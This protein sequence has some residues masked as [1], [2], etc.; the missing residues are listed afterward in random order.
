MYN[1]DYEIE[2][3]KESIQ[4]S[5]QDDTLYVLQQFLNQFH[6]QNKPILDLGSGDG[7]YH[8]YFNN[9]QFIGLDQNKLKNNKPNDLLIE[10]NIE[11]FPYKNIPNEY[12]PFDFIFSLDTFEHLIRPDKV[13]DYLYH[14][15]NILNKNG[16]I[17]I[18][19]PN[20]NTL[21]DKLNNI[22][23]CIYNPELKNYT[24][25]RWNA[26]HLRFFDINSL[27]HMSENI[28]YKIKSITGSNFYTSELFKELG[29]TLNINGLDFG[30][31]LRN[32]KFSLY[33][34]NICVLLQK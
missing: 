14:D 3:N 31:C 20:I 28:G 8:Q 12:I 19:V 30:N 9:H 34:P 2:N 11:E 22:N 29:D 1:K 5:K 32:T 15:H 6:N 24:S 21:D 23:P 16:Y 4:R 17:F 25:N 13:L 10:Q 18:S 33:A 7:H 27:I 26:T